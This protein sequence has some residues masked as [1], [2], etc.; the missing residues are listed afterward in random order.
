MQIDACGKTDKGLTRPNNEDRYAICE[1]PALLV[2]AD[3]MGG[4]A[5]GEIASQ[6]AI[7]ATLD[8]VKK[9]HAGDVQIEAPGPPGLSEEAN[10]LGAAIRA[11]NQVIF[12][13]AKNNTAWRKMG[14]TIAAV[15]LLSGEPRAVIAHVGDS[16]VYLIRDTAIQQL[17]KDHSII[18]EQLRQGL[19]SREEARHSQIKNFITRALGQ[20]QELEVEL[21]ELVIRPGDLLLLCTDGLSSMVTDQEILDIVSQKNELAAKCDKLIE[22]AINNGGRD[23]VTVILAQ[24][25]SSS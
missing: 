8:Q 21:G 25:R 7:E 20:N 1:E 3:G 11:A 13:A 24:S 23:N 4:H 12:Q 2:V 19:L 16:R 10:Q 22:Q 17:T 15:W 9:I 14:T 6:I 18:G 5:A